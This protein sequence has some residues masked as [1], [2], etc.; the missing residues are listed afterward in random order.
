MSDA[1]LLTHLQYWPLYK[2]QIKAVLA[3]FICTSDLN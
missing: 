3:A 2:V 1:L